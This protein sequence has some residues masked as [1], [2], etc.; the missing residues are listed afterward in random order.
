M[1]LLAIGI[2]LDTSFNDSSFVSGGGGGFT[3]VAD[4]FD[5][6]PI[7]DVICTN[8]VGLRPG[9]GALVTVTVTVSTGS[10]PSFVDFA[11]VVDPGDQIAELNNSNNAADL[12]GV[13]YG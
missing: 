5:A 3:C 12:R 10:S 1:G 13:S 8:P 2:D 11:A 6:V 4:T 9:E 7:F